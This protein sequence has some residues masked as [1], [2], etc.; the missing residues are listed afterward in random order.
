MKFIMV[1][2]VIAKKGAQYTSE[3]QELGTTSCGRT[4]EEALENV[5]D[6]TVLY[7]NTLEDLGEFERLLKSKGVPV[8]SDA[9]ATQPVSCPPGSTVYSQVLPVQGACA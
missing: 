6:A 4:K 7:L 1:T 3:C 5:R 2:L 9:R 8:Y